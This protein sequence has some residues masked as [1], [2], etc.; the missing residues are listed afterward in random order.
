LFFFL[1]VHIL[2]WL[3]WHTGR[4]CPPS[5]PLPTS[6]LLHTHTFVFAFVQSRKRSRNLFRFYFSTRPNMFESFKSNGITKVALSK[7]ISQSM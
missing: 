4:D 7:F 5:L 1:S 3:T 2:T 6:H